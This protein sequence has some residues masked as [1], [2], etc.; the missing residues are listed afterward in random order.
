MNGDRLI[1]NADV[2]L[3]DYDIE[4]TNG[5]SGTDGTD[6][7]AWIG[8]AVEAIGRTTVPGVAVTAGKNATTWLTFPR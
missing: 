3:Y 6:E 4:E 8:V 2:Q 1:D 7:T 5:T